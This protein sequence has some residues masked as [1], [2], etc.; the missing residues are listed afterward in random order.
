[1]E[2]QLTQADHS[3]QRPPPPVE[4]NYGSLMNNTNRKNV[5]SHDKSLTGSVA[6]K[7]DTRSQCDRCESL[8]KSAR[9]QKETMSLFQHVIFTFC[10]HDGK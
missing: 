1:M 4:A 2:K 9:L 10:A 7:T 8:K 5:A 6:Q 3:L